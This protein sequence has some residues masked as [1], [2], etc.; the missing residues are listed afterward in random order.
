MQEYTIPESIVVIGD[1]AT[2]PYA[3]PSSPENRDAISEVIKTHDGIV[4]AY[5]GSLTV[6]QDVWKAY[7]LLETLEHSAK[8]VTHIHLL[9]GGKPLPQ[10]YVDK[11]RELRLGYAV[12][13]P[14]TLENDN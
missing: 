11:M 10:H 7:F 3:M 13:S 12:Y 5:H 6:G 14:D 1:V 2:T 8:I 9:G 4:L